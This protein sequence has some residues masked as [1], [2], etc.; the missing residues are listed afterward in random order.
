MDVPLKK[1]RVDEKPNFT[2]C[3]ILQEVNSN[4]SLVKGITDEAY[5]NILYYI[6]ARA[7]YAEKELTD[8][9]KSLEGLSEEDLKQND[10]TFHASCKKRLVSS[11]KLKRAKAR[12]EK[13]AESK[14]AGIL[15]RTAGRPSLESQ[16]CFSVPPGDTEIETTSRRISRSSTAMYNR[17]LCFFCQTH[18]EKQKVLAIQTESRGKQHSEFV[19]NCDNDLYRVFLSSAIRPEDALSIDVKYH[20][21]CWTK[22]VVR[23]QEKKEKDKENVIQENKKSC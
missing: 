15:Y 5:R 11:E 18:N 16:S 8:A 21:P 2:K 10:A 20:Q 14:N 1:R 3:I 19:K 9:S 7:A 23:G 13:A 12:F 22:Y 17:Q 6:L 4:E